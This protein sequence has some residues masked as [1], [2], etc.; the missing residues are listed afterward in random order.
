VAPKPEAINTLLFCIVLQFTID[1]PGSIL[2]RCCRSSTVPA[3]SSRCALKPTAA[4]TDRPR[5]MPHRPAATRAP[6][7]AM[8]FLLDSAKLGQPYAR[9]RSNKVGSG[10]SRTL[11]R[12]MK[13]LIAG[14]QCVKPT[15]FPQPCPARFFDPESEGARAAVRQRSRTAARHYAQSPWVCVATSSW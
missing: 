11:R 10:L 6:L 7:F 8:R 3:Q 2:L 1:P 15:L 14:R 5:S 13:F 9:H 12:N 4:A